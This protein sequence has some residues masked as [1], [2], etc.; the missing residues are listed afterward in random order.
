[1][2]WGNRFDIIARVTS[3]RGGLGKSQDAGNRS[4]LSQH[5]RISIKGGTDAFALI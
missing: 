4:Y 1:M 5:T 2:I 3:G